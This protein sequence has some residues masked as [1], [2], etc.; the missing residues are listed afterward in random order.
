[1]ALS[2]C[3]L[4]GQCE[5]LWTFMH[6][7]D[8]PATNNHAERLLRHIVCMRKVSFGT[9]SPEGS[10]F[11]ERILTAVTTLRLQNRPVLPFLTHAVES[12]LH[13][14]SAPSLLPSAYPPLHAAT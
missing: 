14:H 11:I 2:R 8:V 9:K 12:W 4:L 3:E 5:A 7:E 6:R 13:G 10:R 1:M